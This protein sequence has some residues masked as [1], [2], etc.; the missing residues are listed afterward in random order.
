M[1]QYLNCSAEYFYCLIYYSNSEKW[2]NI[3]QLCFW[4]YFQKTQNEFLHKNP[5]NIEGIFM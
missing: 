4:V 3:L 1:I 2:I 5:T